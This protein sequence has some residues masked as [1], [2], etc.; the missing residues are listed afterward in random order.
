MYVFGLFLGILIAF[1]FEGIS[2]WMQVWVILAGIL[3][4]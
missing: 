4:V 3:L 1:G 2:F